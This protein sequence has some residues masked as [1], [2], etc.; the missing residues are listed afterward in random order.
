MT[1]L[2][3]L[4]VKVPSRMLEELD[5]IAR[6]LGRTRSDLVREGI[7]YIIAKYS[8]VPRDSPIII[9]V[10]EHSPAKLSVV[11]GEKTSPMITVPVAMD[12]YHI[13]VPRDHDI[14]AK[15]YRRCMDRC[16][17]MGPSLRFC[18]EKCETDCKKL[19]G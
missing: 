12:S 1:R 11:H 17:E 13:A 6:A 7:E 18:L 4:T 15:C 8:H 9:S 10:S 3:P 19:V 16:L 2:L 5:R 14:D